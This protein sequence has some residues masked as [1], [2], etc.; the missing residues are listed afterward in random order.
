M[1]LVM[2]RKVIS[3]DFDG[4]IHAYSKG[5]Q[6]DEVYDE[7]VEGALESIN[8]LQKRGYEV[9]ISTARENLKPVIKWMT[10][11]WQYEQAMPEITNRKPKA[12][13]YIDDRAIRFTT[14]KDVKNYF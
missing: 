14:W 7:P 13:A 12:I 10:L 3:V 8:K 11:R 2:S 1:I 5:W 4:V 6:G 9:V